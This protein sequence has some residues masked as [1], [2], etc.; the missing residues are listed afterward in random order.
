MSVIDSSFEI[1]VPQILHFDEFKNLEFINKISQGWQNRWTYIKKGT[2]EAKLWVFTTPRMQFSWVGY[3]NAIMIESSPPKGTI[4]LSFIKTD[5]LCNTNNQKM[6][7][8]ELLVIQSGE[9]TN[10]VAQERNEIFSIVFGES[11]F[12]HIFYR[13]FEMELHQLRFNYR[14]VLDEKKVDGFIAKLHQYFHFFQKHQ[15]EFSN[16]AFFSI[17]EAFIEDLFSLVVFAQDYTVKKHHYTK[18]ARKILEENIDNIYKISDL[19]DSLD[20]SGRTLQYSFKESLGMSPKQYLQYL[21]LNAIRREFL[22]KNSSPHNISEIIAK[23][24]YFHP[25]AFTV[26][27]KNFFGETPTQTLSKI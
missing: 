25:S 7:K 20:I 2:T 5:G 22:H 13:Y 11:F 12:H 8:Y 14:L 4:Q 24:G 9:D 23:Y 17:E 21:R 6:Q 18:K 10:F 3:D 27:Y 19:I 1:F 16:A 15:K 26:A